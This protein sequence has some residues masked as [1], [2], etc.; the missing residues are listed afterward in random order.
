M[1]NV[2]TSGASIRLIIRNDSGPSRR[3]T[4]IQGGE[5]RKV[6]PGDI[7]VIPTGVPHQFT[8]IDKTITYTVIR[9]DADR[10]LPLK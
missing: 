5:S 1:L 9:V 3:S 10:A 6:G 4:A 2:V 8:S 7:I